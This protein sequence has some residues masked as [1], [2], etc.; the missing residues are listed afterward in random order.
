MN[1]WF[2]TGSVILWLW[3]PLPSADQTLGNDAAKRHIAEQQALLQKYKEQQSSAF[4]SYK[5]QFRAGLAAYKNRVKDVWGYAEVS[6]ASKWVYYSE[7]YSKKLVI[8]YQHNAI[9]LQRLTDNLI[10]SDEEQKAALAFVTQA[11]KQ[12][13][14][15]STIAQSIGVAAEDIEQLAT[16]LV[17]ENN[18]KQGE[19]IE[20]SIADLK[21]IKAKLLAQAMR[22]TIAEQRK[23][24]QYIAEIDDEISANEALLSGKVTNKK[25]PVSAKIQ[26]NNTRLSKALLYEDDVA[27]QAK[28]YG[29]PVSLIYAVMEVESNFNPRAQSPIPAFGLMQVVPSTA[30]KDV[31]RYL[32]NGD[33]EPSSK[34]LFQPPENVLFGSTYLSMLYRNYFKGVKDPESRRYC[35]IAAY[36]TGMGNVAA[37][38]SGDGSKNLLKASRVINQMT[39][40]QVHDKIKSRAH[41][42]TKRYITKVLNAQEYFE[43]RLH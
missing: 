9:A 34:Q 12:P 28:Y 23:E 29:L 31:N 13:A 38:F 26:L 40:Q 35:V 19:F 15:P 33:L 6:T 14:G 16:D 5:D 20:A 8:D 3:H 30:G 10:S 4:R 21:A 43:T 41:S 24:R 32:N 2:K 27:K 18:V 37:I 42:E 1:K 25:P 36:N 11:L 39:P 22:L 17:T 7:D